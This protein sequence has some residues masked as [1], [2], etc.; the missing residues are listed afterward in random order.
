VGESRLKF[1]DVTSKKTLKFSRRKYIRCL[2]CIDFLTQAKLIHKYDTI[3]VIPSISYLISK[4]TQQI[5]I[6]FGINNVH[7]NLSRKPDFGLIGP[8]YP[9]PYTKL[10]LN[11]IAFKDSLVIQ[12]VVIRRIKYRVSTRYVNFNSYILM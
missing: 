6:K 2:T 3:A 9:V 4:N 11:L 8:N 7:Q 12:E 10:K 5:S 1:Y